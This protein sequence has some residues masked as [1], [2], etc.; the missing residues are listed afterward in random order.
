MNTLSDL[1]DESVVYRIEWRFKGQR[2]WRKDSRGIDPHYTTREMAERVA[3][4]DRR[5]SPNC[6][7]RVVEG[8]LQ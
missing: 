3:E 7:I 5:T 6:D 1:A 2:R 4:R 8:V